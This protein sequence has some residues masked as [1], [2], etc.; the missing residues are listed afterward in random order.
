MS[1]RAQVGDVGAEIRLTI[2]DSTGSAVDIS[3]A[4]LKQIKVYT[5]EGTLAE[6]LTGSF[7]TDGTDGILKATTTSS[8]LTSAGYWRA[9]AYATIG[10]WTGH[11]S[12]LVIEV[13]P[14]GA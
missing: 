3:T 5:P 13:R 14:V 9:V 2:I 4:S 8:S 6:T 11:S 7:Y 10:D 12:P 1:A